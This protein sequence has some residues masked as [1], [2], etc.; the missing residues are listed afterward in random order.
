MK[1]WI[2]PTIFSFNGISLISFL[3]YNANILISRLQSG[4]QWSVPVIVAGNA[5]GAG[6]A[7]QLNN[8]LFLYFPGDRTSIGGCK[9]ADGVNWSNLGI[10]SELNG[11][12]FNTPS[13]V[14]LNGTL[15]MV[16]GDETENYFL[17]STDGTKWSGS[18]MNAND[19]PP[20]NLFKLF[21]GDAQ[22][23]LTSTR[24]PGSS[25][26]LSLFASKDGNFWNP[27]AVINPP[28]V[29]AGLTADTDA[30][31]VNYFC[32]LDDDAEIMVS[33]SSRLGNWNAPISTGISVTPGSG[34]GGTIAVLPDGELA[35]AYILEPN[36]DIQFIRSSD[37]GDT[38]EPWAF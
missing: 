32:Y 37:K 19:V 6:A 20:T 10:V 27:A 38:W 26:P 9:T 28:L 7:V 36:Q 23:F 18:S 5:S 35:I 14:E 13:V 8:Q 25:I 17:V 33:T 12:A 22:F 4:G 11:N 21:R 2:M 30:D 3:D 15:F 16:T 1:T 34:A 24:S 31:G 29:T